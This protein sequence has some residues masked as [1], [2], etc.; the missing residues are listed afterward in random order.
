VPVA[1]LRALL[2]E[3]DVWPQPAANLG[4]ACDRLSDLIAAPGGEVPAADPA[5]PL[6]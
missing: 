3:L 4:D 5:Y 6:W 2:A 1:A